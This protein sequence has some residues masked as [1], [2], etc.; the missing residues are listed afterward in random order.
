MTYQVYLTR[1]AY[2]DLADIYD[3]IHEYDSVENADYVLDQIEKRFTKLAALPERGHYPHE[4]KLLGI[5]EY[6]EI[7]FKPYRIIYRIQGKCV[8]VYCIVDARRELSPYLTK[9]LF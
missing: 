8:Y 7:L 3:Y 5:K 1:D 4:L 9:R 6:R 2:N